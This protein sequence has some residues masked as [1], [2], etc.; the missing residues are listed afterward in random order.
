MFDWLEANENKRRINRSQLFQ[1]AVNKIRYPHIKKLKPMDYFILTMGL[2]FG[3]GCITASAAK[4]FS[5]LFNIT[6]L[7]IGAVLILS[8]LVTMIKEVRLFNAARI[9]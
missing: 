7:L 1:Q 6:L 8:S 9:R 4:T 3:L 5:F 2:S